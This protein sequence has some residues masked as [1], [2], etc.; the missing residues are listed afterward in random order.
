MEISD[1]TKEQKDSLNDFLGAWL[2]TPIADKHEFRMDVHNLFNK[3]GFTIDDCSS[4][5]KEQIQKWSN[6][7]LSTK[8]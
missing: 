8:Q 4:E 1:L 5:V 3:K 2:S 7:N 6:Q